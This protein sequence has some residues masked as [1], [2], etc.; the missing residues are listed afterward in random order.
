MYLNCTLSCAALDGVNQGRRS[1][2]WDRLGSCY[3]YY[4]RSV[5][6]HEE[7]F[8]PHRTVLPSSAT[9]SV[10]GDLWFI[11]CIHQCISQSLNSTPSPQNQ[12]NAHWILGC[13][14]QQPWDRCQ[15]AWEE[16]EEVVED[17]AK[18]KLNYVQLLFCAERTTFTRCIEVPLT[19]NRN[20][21]PHFVSCWPLRI[22]SPLTDGEG[23]SDRRDVHIN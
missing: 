13:L 11:N 18:C 4:Y 14:Q 20:H 21:H 8:L 17:A 10:R 1:V 22:K 6:R 9:L 12:S 16:E 2:L 19:V 7:F 3:C 23:E 15:L 5:D